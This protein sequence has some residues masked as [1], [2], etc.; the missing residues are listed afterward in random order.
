MLRQNIAI[1]L[2]FGICFREGVYIMQKIALCIPYGLRP[3]LVIAVSLTVFEPLADPLG[4][5]QIVKS[6]HREA[7]RLG[8]AI[9]G[10]AGLRSHLLAAEFVCQILQ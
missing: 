10:F 1:A 9:V 8:R 4:T 2:V 7:Y 6:Q 5:R 3:L